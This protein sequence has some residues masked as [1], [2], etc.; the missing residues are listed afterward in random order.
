MKITS[1]RA[2][3]DGFTVVELLI[4]SAVFSVIML[5]CLNSFVTIGS[6]YYKG[7]TITKTQ[8]TARTIIDEIAHTIQFSNANYSIAPNTICIGNNRYTYTL[9]SEVNSNPNAYQSY[10]AL[11]RE[12]GYNSGCATAAVNGQGAVAGSTELIPD[13][14]QLDAFDISDANGP[15]GDGTIWKVHVKVVSG[16]ND[17]ADNILTGAPGAKKCTSGYSG[18]KFCAVSDLTTIV[19]GRLL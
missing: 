11:Q 17:P 8:N 15:G 9:S 19:T 3:S 16:S 12:E 1:L 4:A 2:V 18:S 7:V 5:I 10:H 14:M 13:G 6:M